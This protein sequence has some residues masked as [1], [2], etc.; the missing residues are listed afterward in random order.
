[1]AIL[2]WDLEVDGLGLDGF[3]SLEDATSTSILRHP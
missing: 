2:D 3:G 1:M